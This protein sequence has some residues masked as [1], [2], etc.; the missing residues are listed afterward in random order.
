[1]GNLHNNNPILTRSFT[2]IPQNQTHIMNEPINPF[3]ALQRQYSADLPMMSSNPGMYN[4]NPFAVGTNNAPPLF[5]SS[6]T[7]SS[8]LSTGKIR[9]SAEISLYSKISS[10]D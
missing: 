1:M 10:D 5:N 7:D 9:S 6:V 8:I 2:N 4:L 3:E